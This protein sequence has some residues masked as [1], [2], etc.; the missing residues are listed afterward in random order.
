MFT[1]NMLCISQK[2]R[3]DEVVGLELYV[4]QGRL[5]EIVSHISASLG[6]H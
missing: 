4:Q 1:Y 2:Q 5:T 3:V 6:V